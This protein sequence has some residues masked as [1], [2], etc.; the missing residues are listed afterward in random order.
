MSGGLTLCEVFRSPRRE[1]MYLYVDRQEGLARVPETLLKAFGKPEKAL[2]LKLD[3]ERKL[4]RADAAEVL[5]AIEID[6]YYL[7]MPPSVMTSSDDPGTDIGV[8]N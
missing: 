3:R 6:G 2:L 5:R 4:A 1:G 8:K 7:Q